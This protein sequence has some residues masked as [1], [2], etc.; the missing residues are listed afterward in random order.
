[1]AKRTVAQEFI[2]LIDAFSGYPQAVHKLI[3]SAANCMDITDE[4][5]VGI[6]NHG[7]RYVEAASEEEQIGFIS[8]VAN[9]IKAMQEMHDNTT[10]GDNNGNQ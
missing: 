5:F 7:A 9:A 3:M 2:M 8:E 10:G 4:E 1:M 6:M